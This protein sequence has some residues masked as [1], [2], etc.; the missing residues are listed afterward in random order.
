MSVT[1]QATTKS[2][3]PLTKSASTN[4]GL[5]QR[6]QTALSFDHL[7]RAEGAP[8]IRRTDVTEYFAGVARITPA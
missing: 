7:V 5:M 4:N 1:G 8:V 3:A 2:Q 6:S